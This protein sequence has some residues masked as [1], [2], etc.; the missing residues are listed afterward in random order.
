MTQIHPTAIIEKGAQIAASASVGPYAIIGANCVLEENVTIKAHVYLDGYT[1]VGAGTTIWP[2]AVIGTKT[3]D[4]KFRGEKTYVKIGKNCEIRECVTIN[5]SCE[6]G[7]EVKVGNNCLIM[8][9]C[10]IAH[11]CEV[12][13]NVIMTNNAT[14]GGHV[15]VEDFAIIG[16]LT[17]VHQFS[18][19]GRNAMV[20]G[21]SRVTNDVPPY[22]IGAGSPYRLAGLNL[23]GL[24]RHKF[25]LE[26]RK[27]LAKAFRLLYRSGLSVE[28]G[29]AAIEEHVE[30]IPEVCHFVQFCRESK[31]GL[32]ATQGI[33][34][35]KCRSQE[36]DKEEVSE[37]V[38]IS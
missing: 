29:L 33:K 3:Q 32:I 4:R 12:G 2:G 21:M 37:S 13:N 18:R 35:L 19:I 25:T 27:Q 17:A 23:V 34:S 1:I 5:S 14:L 15:I 8:A 28:D 20:G 36:E 31:R 22:T 24:R 6:E 26:T 10:H 7:T 9:Y 38:L 30:M 11:N 16:G